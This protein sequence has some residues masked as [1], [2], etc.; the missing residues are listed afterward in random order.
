M[1]RDCDESRIQAEI[2]GAPLAS[3]NEPPC[4]RQCLR[5]FALRSAEGSLIRFSDYRGKASVVLI[6]SDGGLEA[7]GL[8]ADVA[9]RYSELRGLDAEVIATV[10]GSERKRLDAEQQ[11][12]YPVL[13]DEE[14]LVYRELG[15]LDAQQRSAAAVYIT[16]Q[17]GE[18]FAVYRSADGERLPNVSEI[19]S[20]LEF[21]SFQCPEC[22]PPEWP[23]DRLN[24][25]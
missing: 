2:A 24:R 10:F 3:G 16:D 25:D 20:R 17:F 13:V 22:E 9:R 4:L 14:G 15:A 19:L 11:L 23:V 18:V 5:D 12:P 1:K 8:M 6:L 21:I 7:E